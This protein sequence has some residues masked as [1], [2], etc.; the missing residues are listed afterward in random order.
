MN[1]ECDHCHKKNVDLHVCLTCD[2]LVCEECSR[3]D[4]TVCSKCEVKSCGK[5]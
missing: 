4:N 3:E 2:D 1:G 5:K